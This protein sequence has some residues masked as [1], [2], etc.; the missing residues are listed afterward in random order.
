MLESLN[1]S[2]RNPKKHN[3]SNLPNQ[4]VEKL[5]KNHGVLRGP[6]LDKQRWRARL[7]ILRVKCR[8]DFRDGDEATLARNPNSVGCANTWF[9]PA[10]F[11][12]FHIPSCAKLLHQSLLR[13]PC[14]CF[15]ALVLVFKPALDCDY[16]I[17]LQKPF[18]DSS[19][20]LCRLWRSHVEWRHC[21]KCCQLWE[22][23]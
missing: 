12:A 2:F 5:Q 21:G 1:Y 13:F 20:L 19:F 23:Y 7:G 4:I 10:S 15:L 9:A 22:K 6:Q 11:L 3:L 17:C 14:W 8:T 16:R 18:H